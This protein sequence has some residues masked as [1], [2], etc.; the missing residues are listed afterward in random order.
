ME[1][2]LRTGDRFIARVGGVWDL[3]RGQIV[4]V[5]TLTGET[6]VKRLAALEG[7]RVSLARGVVAINRRSVPLVAAGTRRVTHP[8]LKVTEA[9]LFWEQF[10][11]EARPHMIQ[12]LGP[13]EVDDMAELVVRPGQIFLLG[14]NRDDSADS[15]VPR[16]A[17]GLEQVPVTSVIGHPVLYYWPPKKLGSSP[18]EFSE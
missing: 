2:T 15:R 3:R 1:P 7:D 18:K 16:L 11:G 6:Y 17:G 5:R 4:L 13:T 10:P 9:Q 12:D 14:D 8:H